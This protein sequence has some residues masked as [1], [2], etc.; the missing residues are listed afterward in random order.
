MVVWY[1]KNKNVRDLVHLPNI[2]FCCDFINEKKKYVKYLYDPYTYI[3][4]CLFK[5]IVFVWHRLIHDVQP[6]DCKL[7]FYSCDLRVFFIKYC[8]KL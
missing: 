5:I 6:V 4:L 7:L 3:P 2:F 1:V 8:C